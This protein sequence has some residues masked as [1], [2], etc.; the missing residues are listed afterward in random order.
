VAADLKSA[1]L[2]VSGKIE[3]GAEKVVI[4]VASPDQTKLLEK[5]VE[6]EDGVFKSDIKIEDP[7]L[8]YPFTYGGQPLYTVKAVI[9]DQHEEVRKIG[10]RRLRLLQH[11]LKEQ[12]GT[13]FL[14]EINNI[15]TFLGGSCWIPAD[16]LLPR[17]T[18]KTYRDWVSLAKSGNQASKF[19]PLIR[20]VCADL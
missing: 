10:F 2:H 17:V 5:T 14:F 1:V 19:Y 16:Y 13:S 6:I 9:P 15:R 4:H 8:W 7:E 18:K 12:E 3:G 20:N 11:S